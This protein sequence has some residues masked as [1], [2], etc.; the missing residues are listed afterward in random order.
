[1]GVG[2]KLPENTI[3]KAL[4]ANSNK[5]FSLLLYIVEL[6]PTLAAKPIALLNLAIFMLEFSPLLP[7]FIFWKTLLLAPTLCACL[8]IASL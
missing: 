3:W 2:S 7:K 5:A 1:E 8:F 4:E 6:T